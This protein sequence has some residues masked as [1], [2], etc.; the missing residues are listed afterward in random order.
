MSDAEKDFW[1]RWYP[2][3]FEAD[4]PVKLMTLEEEG[5]YH[6]LLD[7][8]W[9]NGS[10]PI[11]PAQLARICK[12]VTPAKMRRLWS[13]LA[14]C[15]T[16]IDTAEGPRYQNR[17]LERERAKVMAYRD[18]RS[19]Q[20][21]HAAQTRWQTSASTADASPEP[22]SEQCVSNASALPEQCPTMP[23]MSHES[24]RVTTPTP[25]ARALEAG[26]EG[27]GRRGLDRV[28]AL[29]P[30]DESRS[31]LAA[32]TSASRKPDAWLA[33]VGM[34]LQ[35]GRSPCTPAQVAQALWDMHVNGKPPEVAVLKS[36]IAG[37][38]RMNA[39]PS[40][41]RSTGRSERSEAER[42]A[43]WAAQGDGHV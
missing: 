8:Q 6:R 12:N 24:R 27:G 17:R 36:Y 13:A 42:L 11:E 40:E 3:D 1:Y 7:H 25:S 28:A 37:A 2:R 22:C 43:A 21:R 18:Q 15:F 41:R 14:A 39:P 9:I 31:A 20:A 33:E 26:S 34:W 23:V 16:R 29:L 5:A 38:A 35:G 32:L 30:N 10:L 4:E 19:A